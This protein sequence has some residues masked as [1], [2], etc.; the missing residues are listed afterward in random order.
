M[1]GTAGPAAGRR[2]AR[3]R[4][5]LEEG[6]TGMSKAW[7]NIA[8]SLIAIGLIVAGVVLIELV[9]TLRAGEGLAPDLA[10]LALAGL[11]GA[12]LVRLVYLER[13]RVRDRAA[14]LAEQEDWQGRYGDLE[15][16]YARQGRF[17]QIAA[18]EFKNPLTVILANAELLLMCDEATLAAPARARAAGI[19][20]AAR[21]LR[22]MIDNLLDQGRLERGSLDP[23]H[24]LIAF[25]RL[26]QEAVETVAGEGRDRIRLE[27]V[28]P[29]PEVYGNA[30]LLLHAV[31]N[32]ISNALKYSPADSPV[33]LHIAPGG[34]GVSI[35][36]Q[37][38]GYGIT[39]ADQAHLFE[40]YYRGQV[41]AGKRPPGTGLGLS[42][43]RETTRRFGGQVSVV[44]APGEGSTFTIWLPAANAGPAQRLQ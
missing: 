38:G 40:P 15:T 8:V 42:I 31:A 32:L 33:Y 41:P 12:L 14:Y 11:V 39:E 24:D 13:A 4:G 21:Q 9:Y 29:L 20:P 5:N 23:A 25:E 44:S 36:V 3:P 35:A 34:D 26:A 28:S 37:D 6:K 30:Q 27:C 1:R 7:T 22:L 16:A 17:L 43:V 18:H 19:S 2:A 10:T